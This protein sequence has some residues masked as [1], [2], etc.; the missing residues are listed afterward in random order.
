M[1]VPGLVKGAIKLAAFKPSWEMC[2]IG[3]NVQHPLDNHSWKLRFFVLEAGSAPGVATQGAEF[4]P[5]RWCPEP[6]RLAEGMHEVLVQPHVS[7]V[8]CLEPVTTAPPV[9]KS[10][11]WSVLKK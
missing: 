9:S 2:R 4:L 10:V 3:L 6:R 8:D 7:F 5:R 11:G 1:R